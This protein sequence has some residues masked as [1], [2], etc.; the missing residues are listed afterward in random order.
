MI[1][2]AATAPRG[3]AVDDY[4]SPETLKTHTTRHLRLELVVTSGLQEL[5]ITVGTDVNLVVPELDTGGILAIEPTG[6]IAHA[7][8]ATGNPQRITA[9]YP[10]GTSERRLN[11]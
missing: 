4:G 10:D 11:P 8:R 6:G 7:T 1:H 9:F 2:C 5:L 3:V